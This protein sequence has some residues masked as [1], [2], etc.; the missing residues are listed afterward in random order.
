MANGISMF[1]SHLI[2]KNFPF[3][4]IFY[5]FKKTLTAKRPNFDNEMTV[6]RLVMTLV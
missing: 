6:F 5:N 1:Y 4:S 3:L 2:L